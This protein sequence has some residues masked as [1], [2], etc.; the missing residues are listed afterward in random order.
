MNE[1]ACRIEWEKKFHPIDLCSN[2]FSFF[3]KC[4][5]THFSWLIPNLNPCLESK[6][7]FMF[8]SL[9]CMRVC[10][11]CIRSKLCV[12]VIF[13][14]KLLFAFWFY[15]FLFHFFSYIHVFG[16]CVCVCMCVCDYWIFNFVW[17]SCSFLIFFQ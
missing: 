4:T 11:L 1:Q 10:V 12:V 9:S 14:I 16:L 17:L 5:S 3:L 7:K 13:I 15:W 2:F 6:I 8:F